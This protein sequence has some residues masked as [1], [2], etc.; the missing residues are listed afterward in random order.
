MGIYDGPG[1]VTKDPA[2]PVKGGVT[3]PDTIRK[4]IGATTGN[5]YPTNQF[6]GILDSEPDDITRKREDNPPFD[7]PSNKTH[8]VDGLNPKTPQTIQRG[9]MRSLI[10][11]PH[12]DIDPKGLGAPNRRLFFQFNPQAIQRSVSQTPGAMLPLLQ[13]PEQLMQP[14]P[15]VSTFGFSLMFNRESEVNKGINPANVDSIDLPNGTPSLVSQVG[16]LADILVLDT[17]TGQGISSDMIKALAQR[18][19]DFLTQQMDAEKKALAN[20]PEEDRAPT[21]GPFSA[22]SSSET[23]VEALAEKF[24]VNLGNSAFLNP[25]PFRVMF[26]TLFMVEGIATNVDVNFTKFSQT[27]VPTQCTVNISMYALYIGFAK[28]NTFLYDNLINTAKDTTTQITKDEEVIN[29]L[30]VGLSSVNFFK[31]TFND[32][33]FDKG[34]GFNV[35]IDATRTSNFAKAI[36]KKEIKD[37]KVRINIQYKLSLIP[38]ITGN[39]PAVS[40]SL[41][42]L[43]SNVATLT[44]STAHGINVGSAITVTGVDATFDG[45]YTVL[46]VP[47]TTTLTYAKI[48]ANVV[49]VADTGSITAVNLGTTPTSEE[50]SASSLPLTYK[51]SNDIPLSKITDPLDNGLQCSDLVNILL[52]EQKKTVNRSDYISFRYSVEL[53]GSGD[54]GVSVSAPLFYSEQ[55]LNGALWGAGNTEFGKLLA[56]PSGVTKEK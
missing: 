6:F 36:E 13:S 56:V 17:I 27:M 12:V 40:V 8:Y 26:S 43:T 14:V 32:D 4:R 3:S 28:K 20:L 37:V 41:K 50:W 51:G 47:T 10:T 55:K 54:T 46:T 35:S 19:S 5:S 22:L 18:Q 2:N 29:Q 42:S 25:Q 45:N 11:D 9:Y 53:A 24:R 1:D 38:L 52:T 49:S 33:F 16:V 31:T 30:K 15:G 48:N 44:T 7:W 39:S 34:G 21:A 23:S